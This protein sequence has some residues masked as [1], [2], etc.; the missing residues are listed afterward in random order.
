M[1]A[2]RTDSRTLGAEGGRPE[3]RSRARMNA[4]LLALLVMTIYVGFIGIGVV[5]SFGG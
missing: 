5:K 3:Q 1:T 2:Q 4:W